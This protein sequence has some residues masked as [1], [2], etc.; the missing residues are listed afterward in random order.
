M[1]N[2]TQHNRDMKTMKR[3]INLNLYLKYMNTF[4]SSWNGSSKHITKENLIWSVTGGNFSL[5]AYKSFHKCSWLFISHSSHYFFTP[6]L[7][8]LCCVFDYPLVS[9]MS[10]FYSF[11]L[12]THHSFSVL[13]LCCYCRSCSLMNK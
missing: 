12:R 10:L 11:R 6:F 13:Y 8:L 5:F 9:L 3:F 4:N 2:N 7:F 1:F